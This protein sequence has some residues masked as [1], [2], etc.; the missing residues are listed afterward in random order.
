LGT[1][2]AAVRY[3]AAVHGI[4]VGGDWYDVIAL[5]DTHLL[6]VVG[7]VSGRGLQAAAVMATLLYAVRA[8][9]AEGYAPEII[10]TKLSELLNLERS[11]HFATVLFILIDL[12]EANI[13]VVNAGHPPPLLV[14]D[15][16]GEYVNTPIGLPVGISSTPMY[17]RT[18]VPLSPGTTLLAFTDGLIERRGESLEVGLERLRQ[19]ATADGNESLE[20]LLT[21]LVGSQIGHGSAD[22]TVLLG[23]RWPAPAELRMARTEVPVIVRRQFS[24]DPASVREARRFVIDTLAPLD[25]TYE[26]AVAVMTSELATNA[27]RHSGAPEFVVSVEMGETYFEVSVTDRGVGTPH[28]RTPGPTEPSGRGLQ[29]VE[30]LAGNWGIRHSDDGLAKTVWFQIERRVESP[31]QPAHPAVEL[32]QELTGPAL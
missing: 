23:L 15:H 18:T 11:G 7:D 22:D 8:Y 21:S 1:T 12:E 26:Q 3:V 5:D 25:A 9:A 6:A 30:N 29:L 24:N 2:E 13:T 17:T 20:R 19:A 4:H 32:V 10:L 27:I 31:A 16:H 28:V 14:H